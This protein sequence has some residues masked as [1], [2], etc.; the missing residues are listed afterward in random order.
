[1]STRRFVASRRPICLAP[2]SIAVAAGIASARLAPGAWES[3]TIAAAVIVTSAASLSTLRST[4][5]KGL[6]LGLAL[7]FVIGAA[8]ARGELRRLDGPLARLAIEG[9]QLVTLRATLLETP[10]GPVDSPTP[11]GRHHDDR[12]R[13]DAVVRARVDFVRAANDAWLP[14]AGEIELRAPSF[15]DS[16]RIGDRVLVSGELRAPPTR[17]NDGGYDARSAAIVRGRVGLL[18]IAS[19]ESVTVDRSLA[20]AHRGW[21]RAVDDVRVRSWDRICKDFDERDAGWLGSLLLGIRSALPRSDREALT[22][23]GTLHFFAISGLHVALIGAMLEPLLHQFPLGRRARLVVFLTALVTYATLTG[24]SVSV[25]R[26]SIM[27]AAAR[28]GSL[29]DRPRESL[30]ALSIAALSILLFEPLALFQPGFQLSFAA[31]AAILVSAR[32]SPIDH[33]PNRRSRFARDRRFPRWLRWMFDSVRRTTRTTLVV[34]LGTLPWTLAYFH[35]VHPAAIPGAPLLLPFVI[36][37][38][39]GGLAWIGIATLVPPL[40]AIAGRPLELV[41]DGMRSVLGAIDVPWLATLALPPANPAMWVLYL[42]AGAALAW[43]HRGLGMA[44]IALALIVYA[45]ELRERPPG[46]AVIDWL[47]VGH[48]T[49]TLL[50]FSDGRTLLYDAG[51]M[52]NERVG[53]RVI[54]PALHALRVRS[55]DLLVLSHA[56]HDHINGARAVIDALRVGRLIVPAGFEASPSGSNLVR[57][58]RREGLPVAHATAGTVLIENAPSLE[59]SFYRVTVLHP[60]VGV[61]P[62]RETDNDRSLVLRIQVSTR[63]VLLTGDLEEA[64]IARLLSTS[65]PRCDVLVLPHHGSEAANLDRLIRVASPSLVVVSGRERSL[66]PRRA[67]WLEARS[68]PWLATWRDGRIRLSFVPEPA[69]LPHRPRPLAM[70]VDTLIT[71]GSDDVDGQHPVELSAG[72]RYSGRVERGMHRTP[73]RA[74]AERSRVARSPH[75]TTRRSSCVP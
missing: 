56:D 41:L 62:D 46:T 43:R 50:R 72:L 75:R 17:R 25:V 6:S 18:R 49:S 36:A 54:L 59:R 57:H 64:G 53:E 7:G 24:L 12:S 42:A 51:S 61:R 16:L 67:A 31:V 2:I 35:G 65:D 30:D 13:R 27:I 14:M 21:R 15:H 63:T 19:A 44:L 40:A 29:V 39:V 52:A 4:A 38:L 20:P 55:L 22:R 70:Q 71:P 66:Q 1:M 60:S 34:L 26:A 8:H 47:D 3:G 37:T 68:I 58:A 9:R 74:A 28:I 11:G 69:G 5:A 10:F 23:T 73:R 33:R 45:T 32:D 48:G